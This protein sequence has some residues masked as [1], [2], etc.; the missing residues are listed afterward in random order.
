MI[1]P[2]R[3]SNENYEKFL[4]L[5]KDADQDLPD[6]IEAKMRLA[7]LKG[8]AAKGASEEAVV[9][10]RNRLAVL[11]LANLSLAVEDEYFWNKRTKAGFKKAVE[12]FE[13]AIEKN[14]K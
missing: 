2:S 7:K 8:E 1:R 11:P 9:F 6:L 5:W 13:Q 3:I 10:A 14:P 4:S 12:Y